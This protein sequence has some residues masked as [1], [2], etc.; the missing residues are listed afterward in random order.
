[1]IYNLAGEVIASVVIDTEMELSRL[2]DLID[3]GP[4]NAQER[5]LENK[6]PPG[7]LVTHLLLE[8]WCIFE[9]CMQPMTLDTSGYLPVDAVLRVI[10]QEKKCT[11]ACRVHRPGM[12]DDRHISALLPVVQDLSLTLSEAEGTCQEFA[13]KIRAQI[14]RKTFK[15]C[16][17]YWIAE[18][19][20]GRGNEKLKDFFGVHI[21]CLV[22]QL[23]ITLHPIVQVDCHLLPCTDAWV[24]PR[25]ESEHF[26]L[27]LF[28]AT[29]ETWDE[30]VMALEGR[31]L[32]RVEARSVKYL[33][34]LAWPEETIAFPQDVG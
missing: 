19:V 5:V 18:A 23:D 24:Y 34:E 6:F 22:V 8:G 28:S 20:H 13:H 10:W 7:I 2:V 17:L 9:H 32:G 1:M 29:E 11:V 16:L 33:L 25:W 12:H 15:D 14:C 4:R 27:D 30:R 3:R 26:L 21:P 31:P